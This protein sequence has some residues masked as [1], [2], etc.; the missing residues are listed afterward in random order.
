MLPIQYYGIKV[1]PSL[2]GA[3]VAT[4]E[5]IHIEEKCGDR[6]GIYTLCIFAYALQISNSTI[7]DGNTFIYIALEYIWISRKILEISWNKLIFRL[8]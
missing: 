5:R 4:V 2:R 6:A 8:K 3:D 1:H 7:R